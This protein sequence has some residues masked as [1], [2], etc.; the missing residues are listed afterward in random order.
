ML[1]RIYLAL[2]LIFLYIPVAILVVYSFN[3]SRFGISWGGFTLDWYRAL[4]NDR[5]I[6]R[7][8][9]NTL[10]IG[11]LSSLICTVIGT[12]AAVSINNMK[13]S[14]RKIVLSISSL[15]VA[16]PDIVIGISMMILY[17]WFFSIMGRQTSFGFGTMLLAHIAFCTPYVVLTVLPRF[18]HMNPHIYEAALDLGSPPFPAFIK[19]VLPQLMPGIVTGFLLSFTMSIDDFMVSFFTTG[20][21]FNNISIIVFTMAK[22]GVN[23][24]INALSTVMLAVVFVL[25]IIINLRDTFLTKRGK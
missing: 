24:T 2:V 6:A 9:R 1:K 13:G 17:V 20:G 7:A 8:V 21:G 18:R 22:R 4:F 3:S 16:T 23:P 15:P 14:K 12:L 5:I 10:T 11:I 25:L 19:T